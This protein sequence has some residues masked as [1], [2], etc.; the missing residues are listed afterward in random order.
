MTTHAAGGYETKDW[1]E[2]TYAELAGEPKFTRVSAVNTFQGDLEAES[3][4]DLLMVYPNDN[5]CS[6][7]GLER[8]TGRLGGRTGSFVLQQS[9]TY[10]DGAINTDW[11]VVP[12][13]GTGELSGLRGTG[14]YAWNGVHGVPTPYTLDYDFDE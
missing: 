10:E 6:F 5:Y 9:G 4:I 13:S 8:V 2:K 7:T 14:G 11:F 1:D 3:H 12:G